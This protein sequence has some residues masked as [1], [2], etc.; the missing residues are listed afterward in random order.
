MTVRQLL[1]SLDSRELAEWMAFFRI[2]RDRM[3]GKSEP[4][5]ADPEVLSEK[6]KAALCRPGD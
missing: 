2:E 5:P 3:E 4:K 6:I 1:A